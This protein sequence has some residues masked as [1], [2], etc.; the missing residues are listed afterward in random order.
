MY[1]IMTKK[2]KYQRDI[3]VQILS[4]NTW[5]LAQ[6]PPIFLDLLA[7]MFGQRSEEL[8]AELTD[9]IVLNQN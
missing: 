9:R 7:E 6:A 2:K 3:F 4:N 8:P 1:P 5:K